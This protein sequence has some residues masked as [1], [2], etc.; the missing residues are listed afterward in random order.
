MPYPKHKVEKSIQFSPHDITG[1]MIILSYVLLCP[2]IVKRIADEK[3][4]KARELLR[5]SGMSDVVFWTAHFLN[6]FLVIVMQAVVFTAVLCFS[7]RKL[8]QHSSS[9][10]FFQFVLLYGAQLVLFSM[11]ISVVFSRFV[12]IS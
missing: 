5:M 8:M 12:S 2:L 6:Y 10:L 11:L 7:D 1:V 9:V 3:A 4:T